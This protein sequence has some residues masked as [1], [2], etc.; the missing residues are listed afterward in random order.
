MIMIKPLPPA[1]IFIIGALFIPFFKG[2][3]KSM[4]MLLLPVIGFI[5]L[6][7]MSKGSYWMI[8][9]L[10]Y[11]LIFGRV[12][13]LSMLFGYI[14]IIIAF[15]GTIYALHVKDDLQHVAAFFYAGG[16]LGVTFAGDLFSLYLFWEILAIASVFLIWSRRTEASL[17]AGFRYILVHMFGDLCLLAGIILYIHNTGT[18]EF[19]HIGLKNLASAL[20]FVGFCL[21]A[22]IP[23]LHPWLPDAYPEA[24]P[25]GTLFLSIYTTK[26]AVYILARTFAGTHLL[27]WAGAIM[28][29]FPIF[30]AVI[31]NDMRRVLCY[32]LLNQVGFMVAGIGI[33]T[34]LSLNGAVSHAFCNILF[35][36]L[37]FMATGAVLHTT[38]KIRATDLGGLYKTMPFTCICCMVG[39]ASIGA[40][41]FTNGF[42]SKSMIIAA[43]AKE[44]LPVIWFMLLFASAGVLHHAT[45]K[46]PYFTFF[47]EDSGIRAKEP[48]LNMRVAMGIAA[49][50]C[51]FIGVYPTPLYHILPYTVHYVPY[52]ASHVVGTLQLLMFA[53]LAFCLLI[54][55]GYYPAEMRATNLDADWFYRKGAGALLYLVDHPLAGLGNMGR[56]LFFD[57]IPHSLARFAEDPQGRMFSLVLTPYW[58]LRHTS[59]EG[60]KV[61]KIRNIPVGIAVSIAVIFLSLF[62][63]IF[64]FR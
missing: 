32:S 6:L 3:S 44:H 24:S 51:I 56:A 40:F 57:R 2:R 38:G 20:I 46:V 60:E 59:G 25:T 39:A 37:L 19:G 8:K 61:H 36:G 43:A 30:Y 26:T 45:I 13:S 18:A 54:L 7:N 29:C 12:D 33:G 1:A 42:I 47:S 4:Y 22:G 50:L 41:P 15:I 21:N 58:R 48:P 53:M 27:I 23:P 31:V 35:E 5:N 11:N 14:F 62:C 49:F 28:T 64:F 17:S 9:F 52:T 10:D 34:A 16:A 55:S 63:L